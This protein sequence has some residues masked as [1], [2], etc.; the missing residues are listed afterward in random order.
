[1][2]QDYMIELVSSKMKL[3]RMERGYTQEKMSE[4]LGISKKTLVQIEK[5]RTLAGWAH[6]V[7]VCAL[8]K[9]SE[10]LQSVLGDEPLEVIETVAHRS[11]DRPKG[12][13][14]GGKVWW[15]EM[16]AKGDFRLQQ[17]LISQHYRILDSYDDLWFST[18]EKRDATERLDELAQE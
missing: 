12:K 15:R 4:V 9:N 11:I 18:F 6:V 7:A 13:T 2:D 1:M 5:E 17:N 16:K 3:I 8:F 14:M 10:V